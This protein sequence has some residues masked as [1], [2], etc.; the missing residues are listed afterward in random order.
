L[1]EALAA[2]QKYEV[3][4]LAVIEESSGRLLG[5]CS[6]SDF[7]NLSPEDIANF[8]SRDYL[9][10]DFLK[11]RNPPITVTSACSVRDLATCLDQNSL[12]HV[13]VVDDLF[14]PV[15]IVS[16]T[17]I[18]RLF[19]E[20]RVPK[21]QTLL[22]TSKGVWLLMGLGVPLVTT[23]AVLVAVHQWI[24]AGVFCGIFL[25]FFFALLFY[26]VDRPS[27]YDT[28]AEDRTEEEA[29]RRANDLSRISKIKSHSGILLPDEER[30]AIEMDYV[31]R[32]SIAIRKEK[33]EVAELGIP[34]HQ[35]DR[36]ARFFNNVDKDK[37]GKIGVLDFRKW[38][39]EAGE[40]TNVI[41][42][43]KW[44]NEFDLDHDGMVG[45]C[46]FVKIM[47]Q[48]DGKEDET[49]RRLSIPSPSKVLRKDPFSKVIDIKHSTSTEIKHSTSSESLS[50][51]EVSQLSEV[52]HRLVEEQKEKLDLQ[53]R[54]D[55]LEHEKADL[56]RQ[57]EELRN[58]NIS[59]RTELNQ[60]QLPLLS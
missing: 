21:R 4:G 27:D 54:I 53:K 57:L 32:P 29:R 37:D 13:W 38:M 10:K 51:H 48:K 17:D 59:S 39:Q 44:V 2:F 36:Y 7:R 8:K 55:R 18:H 25:L 12:H 31:K 60:E 45:W 16:L 22:S 11:F 47:F 40:S 41:E 24:W 50:R 26:K 34:R 14:Y 46:E 19:W 20:Y 49:K 42:I 1:G 5:N 23:A 3:S 43:Q 56:L 6:A 52:R 28:S 33:Q 58:K 30:E 9:V 15:G 35:L